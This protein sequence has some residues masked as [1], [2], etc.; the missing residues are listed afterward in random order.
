MN[1]PSTGPYYDTEAEQDLTAERVGNNKA[2]GKA[3][4]NRTLQNEKD[5]LLQLRKQDLIYGTN[6]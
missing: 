6:V 2:S 3:G 4:R 1:H 5:F